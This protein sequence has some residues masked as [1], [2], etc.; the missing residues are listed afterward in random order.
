V[1]N[2][3]SLSFAL[4]L[5]VVSVVALTIAGEWVG[6]IKDALTRLTGHHWLSKGVIALVVFALGALLASALPRNKEEA[7]AAVVWSWVATC[8]VL[9]GVLV[10]FLFFIGHFVSQ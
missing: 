4:V 10:L 3:R 7:E 8:S 2:T 1:L 9:S 6:A 5:T